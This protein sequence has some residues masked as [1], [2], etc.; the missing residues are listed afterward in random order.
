MLYCNLKEE[1]N[2]SAFFPGFNIFS[3]SPQRSNALDKISWQIP[4]PLGARLILKVE[5]VNRVF[6]NKEAS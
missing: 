4:W 3:L 1:D 2:F 6:E 5:L